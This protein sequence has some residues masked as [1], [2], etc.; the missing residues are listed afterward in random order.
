MNSRKDTTVLRE[1]NEGQYIWLENISDVDVR[2][3]TRK[4]SVTLRPESKIRFLRE[5]TK[6]MECF[7]L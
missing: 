7:T 2:I 5:D 1:T 4:I 6:D 3:E